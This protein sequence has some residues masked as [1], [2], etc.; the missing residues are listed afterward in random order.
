M[1]LQACI[2]NKKMECNLD[3][4]KSIEEKTILLLKIMKE[5]QCVKRSVSILELLIKLT[6]SW[7]FFATSGGVPYSSF[8]TVIGAP[9][10]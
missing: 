7:L 5:K 8:V 2:L 9:V 6:K 3:L 1:Q 4:M 10:K